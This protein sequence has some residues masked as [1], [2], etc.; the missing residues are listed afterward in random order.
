MIQLKLETSSVRCV[1][2]LGGA[3]FVAFILVL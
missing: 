3:T 2:L 1:S